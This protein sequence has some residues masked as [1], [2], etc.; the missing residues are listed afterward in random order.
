MFTYWCKCAHNRN[1]GDVLGPY[2]LE[3]FSNKTAVYSAASAS[4]IVV[5][6]SIVEHLPDGY[7]GI[8]AGIGCAN[9][10]TRKDLSNADVRAL[11]GPLTAQR[12]NVR[13]AILADPGLLVSDLIERQEKSFK[14]GFIGHYADR[15]NTF[16]GKQIN[17]KWPIEKVVREADKCESII[18]SSLHGLIL[19]DSLGIKRKWV[20]YPKVQGGGFKFKDYGASIGQ[21]IILNKWDTIDNDVAE[22]KKEQLRKMFHDF[23]SLPF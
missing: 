11:R 4:Q 8:V 20:K 15:T 21:N 12:T 1:F 6:G 14:V 10:T 16:L 19:A 18:T 9:S 2:L 23:S 7:A 17:I 5:C 3:K 22:Y 13:D